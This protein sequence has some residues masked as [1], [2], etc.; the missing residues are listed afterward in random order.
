MSTSTLTSLAILKVDVDR[1]ND[2]LDYLKPFVLQTLVDNRPRLIDSQIVRNYI[3][4]QFGL[5][6]PDA[7]IEI[8]LKR[9]ART[10]QIRKSNRVYRIAGELSDPEL[11]RKSAL[12]LQ[13]IEL[14]LNEL[15]KF[16]ELTARPIRDT[17]RAVTVI[18]AFLS[19][20]GISCLRSYLRGTTIPRVEGTAVTDIV[21]VS[22]FIHDIST[23]NPDL[24]RRFLTIVQGNMLANAL[25]CSDLSHVKSS[26]RRVEFF[27]D[28]P[29]LIQALG[30]DGLLK[31][32][33]TIE[34][35]ETLSKLGGRARYFTHTF[36]ELKRVLLASASKTRVG[37][38][39]DH[40]VYEATKCGM[41]RSDLLLLAESCG[42]KLDGLGLEEIPTPP[43]T[44]D[45]QIDEK[46]FELL[47][48]ND[49]S[50]LN[51]RA[52][53]HDINSV[54][55]I[56]VI[57]KGRPVR[58]IEKCRAIL[59]T[60]NT[61]FAKS[62]WEYGK[63]HDSNYAASS[64]IS[65]LSLANISWLKKPMIVPSI[66]KSQLL[67][68]SYA[69]MQPSIELLTRYMREI[70]RL[71]ESQEFSPNDL[72]LLRS[73]LFLHTEISKATLG[74]PSLFD[75]ETATEVLKRLSD[76]LKHDEN[77]KLLAE[78]EAHRKTHVLL[79]TERANSDE[80][81]NSIRAKCSRKA[82]WSAWA[83]SIPL[84]VVISTLTFSGV[85]AISGN[86]ILSLIMS[87]IAGIISL[88]NTVFGISVRSFHDYMKGRFFDIYL[89]KFKGIDHSMR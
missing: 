16:S 15:M 68:L 49:V 27:F 26:Y 77:R 14:V 3:L 10:G 85:G 23:G 54:R 2:Y 89:S 28:T 47:L 60:S 79:M 50:Y 59:V 82:R 44:E 46:E 1:G 55:S 88:F 84:T 87:I 11:T 41:T 66:P 5:D 70:D 31:K 58:S 75:G 52:R 12:A 8:V 73:G 36:D 19:R 48:D 56:Y 25:L 86:T 37:D 32:S 4:A 24:F 40:I 30:L 72:Q 7:T 29:L 39:R 71:E 69:A 80:L 20:F 33:A 62:A 51:P 76:E 64:V 67:S 17:N 35:I 21:L 13:D 34:L 63:R 74:D 6:I 81:T 18:C 38:A 57:R 42:E 9:I 61:G 45:Y 53:Q 22:N 83:I 78:E 65:D 43:Y